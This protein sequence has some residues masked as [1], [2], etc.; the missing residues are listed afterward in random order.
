MSYSTKSAKKF[1]YQLQEQ[2]SFPT[3]TVFC[4]IVCPSIVFPENFTPC[5]IFVILIRINFLL[6]TSIVSVVG[7]DQS[8]F[9]K[10]KEP[11]I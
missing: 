6:I 1:K 4:K 8:K 2:S 9:D 10:G 5:D 7:K 11:V 3:R